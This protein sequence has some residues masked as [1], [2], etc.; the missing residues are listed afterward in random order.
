MKA[1]IHISQLLKTRFLLQTFAA[2]FAIFL[3]TSCEDFF[4]SDVDKIHIP[5]V[6]AKLVAYSFISPQ[7]T[8]VKVHLYRTQS[9]TQP[10][11]THSPVSNYA[12][13]R[14][15]KKGENPVELSYNYRLN[16]YTIPASQFPIEPDTHYEL[17][18][19]TQLGESLNA[20]CYVPNYQISH[21]EAVSTTM[22]DTEWGDVTTRFSWKVHTNASAETRYFRSNAFYKQY[23]V[24]DD[25]IH[26]PYACHGWELSN[27]ELFILEN[28]STYSLTSNIW[29][30]TKVW[31]PQT[32]S[33]KPS[34]QIDSLYVFA[35]Q[36]DKHYYHFHKTAKEY[37][38]TGD[39][40]PFSEPVIIY[41]NIDGGLGVFAGYN[42]QM[43]FIAE[44]KFGF[45]EP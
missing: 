17:F 25:S 38:Y 1:I 12:Q 24:F 7:D 34:R 13:V 33:M 3:L 20:T 22:T 35:L 37:E 40:F 27:P 10:I 32:G 21:I 36:G 14:I 31:D 6:Q 8:L 19:E 42:M 23:M 43:Y 29:L 16:C 4:L 41:S 26:G 45:D 18:V 15:S 39:D 30:Q 2:L 11:I 5:D 28:Q 44:H 9:Y